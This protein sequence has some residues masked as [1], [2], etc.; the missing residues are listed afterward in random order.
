MANSNE[1]VL[2]GTSK[3]YE[4]IANAAIT[5]GDLVEVMSTGK[6]RRHAT[7]S[8]PAAKAFAIYN[9]HVGKDL[10]QDYA[11]N[12]W[13]QYDEVSSGSEVNCN[14][15]ISAPAIVIGDKLESAGDGT[16]RKHV[17]LSGAFSGDPSAVALIGTA[18]EAVDNSAGAT[19][20]RIRMRVL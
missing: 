2:K 17:A 15:A 3:R 10:T 18:M 12:E 13:L 9:Y 4:G 11:A 16:V 19:K 7:G 1:I 14:V 5:P 20:V 8:G 6:L